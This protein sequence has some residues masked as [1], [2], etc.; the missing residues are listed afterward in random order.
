MAPN[1][2]IWISAISALKMF[3]DSRYA[4]I[5]I[6]VFGAISAKYRPKYC[7]DYGT[8]LTFED[9]LL[10]DV[11]WNFNFWNVWSSM[12]LV[13]ECVHVSMAIQWLEFC[14]GVDKP[15]SRYAAWELCF[16]VY[17]TYLSSSGLGLG[18]D[19]AYL[20]SQARDRQNCSDSCSTQWSTVLRHTCATVLQIAQHDRY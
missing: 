6:S 4:D 2:D 1:A 12:E 17:N 3:A 14:P 20:L 8:K 19:H 11:K 5:Q 18:S 10:Y 7:L 15:L 13:P 16:T 9:D